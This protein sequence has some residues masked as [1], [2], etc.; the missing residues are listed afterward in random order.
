MPVANAQCYSYV[1]T[2]PVNHF[3]L[4]TN[5]ITAKGGQVLGKPTTCTKADLEVGRP[6]SPEQQ[7]PPTRFAGGIS[8]SSGPTLENG[9]AR[10]CPRPV[11]PQPHARYSAPSPGRSQ[12]QCAAANVP[13]KSSQTSASDPLRLGGSAPPRPSPPRTVLLP[14]VF[15]RLLRSYKIYE[16]KYLDPFN[17]PDITTSD[18]R[19][20]GD[21]LTRSGR[22]RGI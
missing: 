5:T 16:I 2:L 14:S 8:S 17:D 22:Y 19:K 11:H 3:T 18:R 9:P 4:I 21:R 15:H 1:G 10:S 12:R 7:P 6:V 13:P 20:C